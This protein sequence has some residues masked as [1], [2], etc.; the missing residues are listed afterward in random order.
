MRGREKRK[1]RREKEKGQRRC[2]C[3][4]WREMVIGRRRGQAGP[5]SWFQIQVGEDGSSRLVDEQGRPADW[6]RTGGVA[7]R[8]PWRGQHRGKEAVGPAVPSWWFGG[9]GRRSSTREE[10]RPCFIMEDA[11]Q[12]HGY[13]SSSA[14]SSL[15]HGFVACCVVSLCH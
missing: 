14:S 7:N 5:S 6:G 3:V 10:V 8:E 11:V 15:D 4:G 13:S 9:R 2:R 1:K 12:R